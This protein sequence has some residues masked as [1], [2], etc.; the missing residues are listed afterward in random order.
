MDISS[1]VN[2]VREDR[3]AVWNTHVFAAALGATAGA[4]AFVCAQQ[5]Y[6]RYRRLPQPSEEHN[7]YVFIAM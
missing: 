3:N 4:T 1:S 5:V 2:I 6:I 7:K